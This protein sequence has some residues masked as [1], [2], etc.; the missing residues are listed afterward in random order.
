MKL[1]LFSGAGVSAELGVPAMRSMA[2]QFAEHL[3]D[4]EV[5][6]EMILTMDRLLAH[7]N[8]DMEHAIDLVDKIVGA[9]QAKRELG[10]AVDSTLSAYA[11]I[12][13]EAEWFVQHACEQID[14]RRAYHIW[15]SVLRSTRYHQMTIASTNYDRAIE[16]A[17]TR[18]KLPF[19]DGF[20]SFNGRQYAPWQGFPN[21]DDLHILKLHGSTDWYHGGSDA[22]FKLRHPMPT[23]GTLEVN[24]AG[25]NN[26]HSALVLP[27]REKKTT[28]PPFPALQT[29][30]RNCIDGAEVAFF[31]GSSLRD[32]HLRDICAECART[33]HTYVVTRGGIAPEFLP[34][35]AR[36]IIQTGGQFLVSTLPAYLKSTGSVH[37]ENM[38]I[39]QGHISPLE[40]IVIAADASAD[41]AQRCSAIET[42]AELQVSLGKDYIEGLLHSDKPD[43]KLNALGLVQASYDR[44]ELLDRAG[45]L[46]AGGDDTAFSQELA[47][48]FKLYPPSLPAEILQKTA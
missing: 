23:F 26:L 2:E 28:Q 22:V 45:L 37:D 19:V 5:A 47:L 35:G 20:E 17:A 36:E 15:S 1:L 44:N 41:I 14:A 6:D 32:P 12:R 4:A 27:S 42:L 16:I 33:C 10:I 8:H 46:A 48:L 24:T 3:R 11:L 7:G 31:V 38:L 29:K 40:Q 18:L 43:V 30:F 13:E 34:E 39:K 25:V 9:E 21:S